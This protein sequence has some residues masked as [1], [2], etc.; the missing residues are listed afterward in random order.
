M[1]I[2]MA[3]RR[4][5]K[6]AKKLLSKQTLVV[7]VTCMAPFVYLEGGTSEFFWSQ[8]YYTENGGLL[9]NT[10]ATRYNPPNVSGCYLKEI[11]VLPNAR[12]PQHHPSREQPSCQKPHP[13]LAPHKHRLLF[14]NWRI[15]ECFFLRDRGVGGRVLT[16]FEYEI[17]G[18]ADSVSN[19]RPKL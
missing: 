16:C 15:G 4:E 10:K 11:M 17:N 14:I 12:G 6:I 2:T 8:V 1:A 19:L 18:G 13:T 9:F 3:I 5:K 7:L